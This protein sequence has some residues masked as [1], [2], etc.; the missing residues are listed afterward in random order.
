[1]KLYR[2]CG[3]VLMGIA[4]IA[5]LFLSFGTESMQPSMVEQEVMG[6]YIEDTN[7]ENA[8]ASIYLN[9]RIFDTLFEA[10]MLL[11]SV[12]GVVHFSRHLEGGCEETVKVGPARNNAIALIVPFIVLFGLYITINGHVSPGGGFQGGAALTGAVICA[13]L[14]R[15]DKCI[16]FKIYE[17][18]EKYIFIAIIV[19]GA[20]FGATSLYLE[21]VE[22]NVAYLMLMN[23]L[24][25]LKVYLG[26]SIIFFR[27]VHY[28]DK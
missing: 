22:F 3:M 6:H 26:L 7:A 27:F 23:T 9:Y 5:T 18:M 24:I 12:M 4:M 20:G 10:L 17:K 11:V 19:L 15:P 8:V 2:T 16:R 1:M 21:Y 13:Y 25:S 28:E 14:V